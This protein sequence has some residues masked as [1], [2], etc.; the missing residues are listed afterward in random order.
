MYPIS[1]TPKLSS[2]K[3]ILI[4][5]MRIEFSAATNKKECWTDDI[6]IAQFEYLSTPLR[7]NKIQ[8]EKKTCSNIKH[9][10]SVLRLLSKHVPSKRNLN[11]LSSVVE[12]L[13][14]L[15]KSFC[16]QLFHSFFYRQWFTIIL[17]K[18]FSSCFFHPQKRAKAQTLNVKEKQ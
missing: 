5:S 3:G 13:K 2:I 17:R 10:L 4:V 15:I 8:Q 12:L 6:A 14:T 11:I 1:Q 16:N 18:N 9:C 7:V